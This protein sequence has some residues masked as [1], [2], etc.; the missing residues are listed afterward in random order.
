MKMNYNQPLV[1]AT[2][3]QAASLMQAVSPNG[4]PVGDP[5]PDQGGD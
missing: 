3:L 1:E 5:V 4:L 2:E